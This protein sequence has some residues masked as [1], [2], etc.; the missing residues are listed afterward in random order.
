MGTS[1]SSLLIE[2]LS[3]SFV[4]R[5]MFMRHFGH[6][7]GHLQ[8]ERQHEMGPND[9]RDDTSMSPDDVSDSSNI[10]DTGDSEPDPDEFDLDEKE[11]SGEIVG[12]DEGDWRGRD[13]DAS[14]I[15]SDPDSD[16]C[17]DGSNCDS[18]TSYASY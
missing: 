10:L 13:D 11:D 14:D 4:D 5:D 3:C 16:G 18:S 1:T 8:Y 15:I 7:V 6:G 2:C 12:D 9:H 17:S